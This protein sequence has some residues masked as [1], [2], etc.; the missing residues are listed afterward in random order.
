MEPLAL[1]QGVERHPE[2]IAAI[3]ALRAFAQKLS[4]GTQEMR[5]ASLPPSPAA[6]SNGDTKPILVRVRSLLNREHPAAPPFLLR[7]GSY[8]AER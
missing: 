5:V 1:Q 2:L 7:V 4:D 3:S 6:H 8:A